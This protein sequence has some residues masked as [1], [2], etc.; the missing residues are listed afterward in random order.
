MASITQSGKQVM[1]GREAFAQEKRE[2]RDGLRE[3]YHAGVQKVCASPEQLAAYLNM[4]VTVPGYT[5]RN[6]ML[7]Y[8]QMPAATFVESAKGWY[9]LGRYVPADKKEGGISIV[10]P[11]EKGR[12]TYFDPKM[13]YDVSQT[14][15]RP[16][17]PPAVHL[18]EG[19]PDMQKGFDALVESFPV[20]VVA[21]E[22]ISTPALYD[23]R[24]K[25]I[26]VND[27]FS[28]YETFTAVVN[29]AAHAT[30][31]RD[32]I[33]ISGGDR[34]YDP[35]DFEFVTTCSAYVVSRRFGVPVPG[36][37]FETPVEV[38][39]SMDLEGQKTMLKI[40]GDGARKCGDRVQDK[41]RPKLPARSPRTP[42]QSR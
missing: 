27:G 32:D 28:D 13:V 11:R 26:R 29:A 23:P 2:E 9:D 8:Q 34:G 22:H 41:V 7:V 10:K 6:A 18:E 5:S 17:K 25:V 12:S 3:L 40:I 31:H 20:P 1:Q 37:D 14:V 36:M 35:A 4:M 15:G 19:S 38:L 21:D 39:G 42:G 24:D 16:V 33:Q 30:L